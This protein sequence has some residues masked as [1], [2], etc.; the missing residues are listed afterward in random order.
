VVLGV[1]VQR[2]RQAGAGSPEEIAEFC[3]KN[4]GVKFD[5]LGKVAVKGDEQAPLYKYL[6]LEGDKPEVRRADQVELH[7]VPHCR[8]GRSGCPFRAGR[9]AR[10]GDGDEGD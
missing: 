1:A 2:F 4:Y 6:N 3:S 9:E 8:N 5:L 10:F 7:Q